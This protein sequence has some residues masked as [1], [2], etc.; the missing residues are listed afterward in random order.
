MISGMTRAK[1]PSSCGLTRTN[2]GT[3]IPSFFV[4]PWV[5]LRKTSTP[6]E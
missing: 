5:T 2:S 4:P 6:C 1:F 3:A